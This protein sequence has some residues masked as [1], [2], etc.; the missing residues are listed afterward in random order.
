MKE[1][2]FGIGGH[3]YRE[4]NMSPIWRKR[5]AIRNPDGSWFEVPDDPTLVPVAATTTPSTKPVAPVRQFLRE[6]ASRGGKARAA[7]HTREELAA[8]G[9]MRRK[10]PTR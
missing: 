7:R 4:E 8:W 3:H 2:P 1:C 9:R 10:P 6:I 5:D